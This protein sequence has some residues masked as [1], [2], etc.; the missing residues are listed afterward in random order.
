MRTYVITAQNPIQ[1]YQIGLESDQIATLE[2]DLRPW[3][4][5]VAISSVTW[6]TTDGD[7]SISGQTESSGVIHAEISVPNEGRSDVRITVSDGTRSLIL[8]VNIITRS[9]ALQFLSDYGGTP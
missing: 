3:L 6:E 5:G 2:F 4:N 9:A 1:R 8:W 7:A